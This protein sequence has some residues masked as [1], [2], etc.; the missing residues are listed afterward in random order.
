MGQA[1]LGWGVVPRMRIW[2]RDEAFCSLTCFFQEFVVK[3]KGSFH[4]W[5][6]LTERDGSWKWVDGTEYRSNY[7]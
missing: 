3:H 4:I 7:R 2:I 5:I 6:G 1:G